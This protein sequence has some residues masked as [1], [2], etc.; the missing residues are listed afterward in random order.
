MRRSG[1]SRDGGRVPPERAKESAVGQLEETRADYPSLPDGP[2][3]VSPRSGRPA[4]ATSAT[5]QR[6]LRVRP[7]SQELLVRLLH[8][9]D[10]GTRRLPALR[11]LLLRLVVGDRA[12]DDH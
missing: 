7:R 1:V 4:L 12:G 10:V 3:Q 5:A 8:D 11:V 6:S 9:P 2:P